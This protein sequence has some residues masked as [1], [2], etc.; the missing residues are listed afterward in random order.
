MMASHDAPLPAQDLSADTTP[1]PPRGVVVLAVMTMAFA[2]GIVLFVSLGSWQVQRLAWKRDLIERVESRIHAEPVPVPAAAVL[3]ATPP[4]DLEYTRVR[5]RGTLMPAYKDTRVKAVT[6][7]GSGFWVMRPLRTPDRHVLMLNLGFVP[8]GW[9]GSIPAPAQEL[10]FTGLLRPSEPPHGFLRK[11]NPW[12]Q[13]W[14]SRDVA[15]MAGH[16]GLGTLPPVFID[17]DAASAAQLASPWPRGGLTVVR[18]RDNHLGYA[19]T[20]FALALL[21][22]GGAWR[23]A[24][25]EIRIRRRWHQHS[26]HLDEAREDRKPSRG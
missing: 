6:E 5:V 18:F 24:L 15:M 8:D 2:A 23:F 19:L 3:Q 12:M 7:A 10:E 13:R 14:Y 4:A 11:N 17:I 9:E 25:E 20:W 16:K 26:R 1:R 22:A 21:V